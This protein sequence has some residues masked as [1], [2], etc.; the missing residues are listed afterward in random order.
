MAKKTFSTI[1]K[2]PAKLR[3]VSK[4][5]I[6]IYPISEFEFKNRRGINDFVCIKS[7][8]WYVEIN[9]NGKVKTFPKIVSDSEVTESIWKTINYYYK[10]LTEK[11]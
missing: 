8:R 5:G 3:Y 4:H 6:L 7:K 11:K 2:D 1:N 10:L 9:N